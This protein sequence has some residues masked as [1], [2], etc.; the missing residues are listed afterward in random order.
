[1]DKKEQLADQK[2]IKKDELLTVEKIKEDMLISDAVYAGVMA[3]KK[4]AEGKQIT[5]KEMEA[6]VKEFLKTPLQ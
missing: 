5:K 2:D 1:M 6:A 3:Q 4:W